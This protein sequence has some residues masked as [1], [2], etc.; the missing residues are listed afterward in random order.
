MLTD[1]AISA[2]KVLEFYMNKLH[3]DESNESI[4]AAQYA[5]LHTLRYRINC[6]LNSL[7]SFDLE[8]K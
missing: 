7:E 3:K 2:K 6:M 1:K 5:N 8:V 4:F